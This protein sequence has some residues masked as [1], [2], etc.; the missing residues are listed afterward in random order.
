MRSRSGDYPIERRAGEVER[1]RIQS[2]ALAAD[3]RAM[4]DRIGIGHGWRCLDLACGPG[5]IT[6][7]LSARVGPGGQVVGLDFDADFVAIARSAPRRPTSRSWPATPMP[8]ACPPA[9]SIS[10][11]CASSPAPPAI[12]TG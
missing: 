7:E 11:T 2:D 5:G 3:T 12:P 8:P 10:S 6:D 1:L 4:L 9:A